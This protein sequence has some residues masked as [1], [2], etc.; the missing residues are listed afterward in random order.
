MILQKDMPGLNYAVVTG[1]IK[2]RKGINLTPSGIPVIHLLIENTVET[3]PESGETVVHEIQVDLWGKLAQILND[4]LTEN[5]GILAEGNIVH[6][7]IEDSA[8]GVHYQNVL[9]ARRIEIISAKKDRK[10]GLNARP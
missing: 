9:K 3:F 1:I 2:K 6:R 5:T 10:E 7:Q 8:G 4:R